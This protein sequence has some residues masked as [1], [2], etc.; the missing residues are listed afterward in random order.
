MPS[1]LEMTDVGAVLQ[2]HA[3]S[4]QHE[5]AMGPSLHIVQAAAAGCRRSGA[6]LALCCESTYEAWL[7]LNLQ[8]TSLSFPS[9]PLHTLWIHRYV[10]YMQHVLGI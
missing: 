1:A 2:A 6:G 7:Y 10:L 5:R 3:V 9:D 4:P 8:P